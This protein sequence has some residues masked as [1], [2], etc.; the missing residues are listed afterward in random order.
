[1]CFAL[2]RPAF[3]LGKRGAAEE[4]AVVLVRQLPLLELQAQALLPGTED[5]VFVHP[6][7]Q[8]LPMLDEGFVGD[9]G[10]FADALLARFAGDDE[11]P[12]GEALDERPLLIAQL[13]PLGDAA[14]CPRCRGRGRRAARTG[15]ARLCCSSG[16]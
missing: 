5:A 3:C 2:G 14:V 8:A 9:L 16:R 12:V 1:L 10:G 6:V 15:G 4:C 7:M 11:A 13:G